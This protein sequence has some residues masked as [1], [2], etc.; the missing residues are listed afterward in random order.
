MTLTRVP[1]ASSSGNVPAPV[2]ES[3]T[4]NGAGE[5][6]LQIQCTPGAPLQV[7][8]SNSLS[9]GWETVQTVNP[10]ASPATVTLPTA[11]L[12]DVAYLRALQ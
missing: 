9:G 2:I 12:P 6:V 4:L 8:Q 1:L 3:I 5:A 7:Q 11:S 10:T